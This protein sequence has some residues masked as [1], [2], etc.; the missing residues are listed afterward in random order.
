MSAHPILDELESFIN[1]QF[2]MTT[3]R[4]RR[5][6]VKASGILK[7]HLEVLRAKEA[8]LERIAREKSQTKGEIID[9][10]LKCATGGKLPFII[11]DYAPKT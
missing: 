10:M 9:D 4:N 11:A 2:S 3:G 5:N 7:R 6:W 8:A 1:E